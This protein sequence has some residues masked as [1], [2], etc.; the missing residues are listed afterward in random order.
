[1]QTRVKKSLGQHFLKN[2]DIS[3]RIVDLLQIEERDQ[4]LEIGPGPGALTD[5]IRQLRPA[6][7]LL[8]EKDDHWA[9]VH[10]HA[11]RDCAGASIRS[12]DALEY[13]WEKLDGPWKIIGN[14]PYNRASPLIWDCVSRVP[15]LSLAVFMTQ[16]EVAQ[17]LSAPP[18]NRVY[19][20]LSV[21]VQSFVRVEW[22]FTVGP[23][24]FFPPPKVDSAVVTMTAL[25][26]TM[27][28][29]NPAALA[30][31]IKLCFQQRRKQLQGIL[32]RQGIV[33]AAALLEELEID[34][35]ARPEI[36]ACAKFHALAL[37]CAPL[38]LTSNTKHD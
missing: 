19:G 37:K 11:L 17:R 36:L 12:M 15:E 14:L 21:W 8:L 2:Q 23:G 9:A 16:K 30:R 34:P 32:R 38:L 7:L 25:P 4:V 35:A 26:R 20:A 24:N 33:D 29:Q 22:G 13:A 3:R 10:A 1:M 28:P 6:R 27:H 18:G 5:R 31:V